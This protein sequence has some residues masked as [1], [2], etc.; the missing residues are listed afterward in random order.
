MIFLTEEM[1]GEY[2]WTITSKLG[3]ILRTAEEKY[4][5]RDK[6]YTIL[7][8]EISLNAQPQIWYPGNCK[9]IAIQLTQGCI[10]N[11]DRAVFQLAH[12]AIHCLSPTGGQNANYLEEGLGTHFSIEYTMNNGHGSWSAELAKYGDALTKVRELLSIDSEIIKKVR[13]IQPTI[14]FITVDNLLATNDK[15]PEKLATELVTKF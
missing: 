7:G 4:G 12:E 11:M 2:T 15:I 13:G 5:N 6:E 9:H 14:A 10:V 1:Q 8:V 3:H